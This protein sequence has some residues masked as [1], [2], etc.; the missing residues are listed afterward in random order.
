MTEPEGILREITRQA[1]DMLRHGESPRMVHVG[2]RQADA[3]ARLGR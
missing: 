2:Q 1:M 3:L